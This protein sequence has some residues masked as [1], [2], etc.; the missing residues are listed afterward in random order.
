MKKMVQLV[1]AA[2]DKCGKNDLNALIRMVNQHHD[3]V[4]FEEELAKRRR[5]DTV[6]CVL[7]SILSAV[8]LVGSAIGIVI[9]LGVVVNL[10]LF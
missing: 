8:I 4:K 9:A 2:K 10:V 7:N 6:Y 5:K 3:Q 1:P